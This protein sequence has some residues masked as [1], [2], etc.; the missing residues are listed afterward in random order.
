MTKPYIQ[1]AALT[2]SRSSQPLDPDKGWQREDVQ[3][4]F[5]TGMQDAGVRRLLTVP[6]VADLLAVSPSVVRELVRYG[7]LA[8][9][10]A[11]RGTER[12]HLTFSPDEIERFIK[13][14]TE[15]VPYDLGAKSLRYGSRKRGAELAVDRAL[16][17]SQL[18]ASLM[19]LTAKKRKKKP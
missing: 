8:Y 14:H 19:K 9:V 10:H 13:R 6:E 12:K 17:G 3:L 16:G 2:Y 5:M 7:E 11:G 1:Q 15:R 18:E 4:A